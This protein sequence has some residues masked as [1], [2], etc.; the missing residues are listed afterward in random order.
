MRRKRNDEIDLQRRYYE[1]TAAKYNQ[2]HVHAEDEHLLALT[3]LLAVFDYL[4]VHSVLDVGSGTGRALLHIKQKR[5][6]VILTGVEPVEALRIIGHG[7]GLSDHELVAGDATQ[8]PFEN[9]AFD[10]V[11]AF[12]VLHH[13][14]EPGLVVAEMLRTARKA[15]FISDA[16]NFGQGSLLVR[17][18]K[19]LIHALGL[20]PLADFL[21]TRGKGY[22]WSEGDG[23][24]YSYSVFRNYAQIHE[25][26]RSIHVFNTVGSGVNSYRAA[27]HVALLGI[28]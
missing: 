26:C 1:Q 8:L 27:S 23:V 15:I 17:G 4:G 13:V 21:K 12:G 9:A 19:Q 28:K 5:P 10:V 6:D 3:F 20:W 2:S 11:C 22:M 14:S 24:T 7:S 18:V 25:A 16:N